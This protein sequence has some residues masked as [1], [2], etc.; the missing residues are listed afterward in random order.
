[1]SCNRV[2]ALFAFFMAL[3]AASAACA[4]ATPA[5]RA[6]AESASAA[7]A[8]AL[9]RRFNMGGGLESLANQVAHATTE[10]G[11]IAQKHGRARAD[12]LIKAAISRALPA[13]QSRWNQ[14]LALVY[15]R[16]F[17]AEQLRSLAILGTSSPYATKFKSTQDAVSA[18]M[19]DLSSQLLQQLVTEALANA[20]KQ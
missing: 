16:H 13:Y 6:S 2:L 4:F 10:F 5:V 9:V 15:S 19:R 3:S 11:V 14:N 7:P 8:L 18:E 17:S 20:A 12:Q 1:M